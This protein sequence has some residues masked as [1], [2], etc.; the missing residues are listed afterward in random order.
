M[1][2]VQR[3][4]S[5][6]TIRAL[7]RRREPDLFRVVPPGQP[8]LTAASLEECR[9]LP[10]QIDDIERAAVITVDAVIEKGHPLAVGG[11]THV[12]DVHASRVEHFPHGELESAESADVAHD[13]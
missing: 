10:G 12:A 3:D 2:S 5:E 9:S 7:Q 6:L 4:R 1:P 13:G 8:F 11:N